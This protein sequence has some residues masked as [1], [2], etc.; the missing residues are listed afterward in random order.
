MPVG[1]SLR[2]RSGSVGTGCQS[3]FGSDKRIW[4]SSPSVPHNTGR[5]CCGSGS[6]IRCLFDTWIRDLGF[7]N[8]TR[9]F[10]DLGSRSQIPNQYFLELCDNFLCKKFYNSLKIGP[11]FFIQHFKNKIISNFVKFE[12]TKKG[13]TTNF[14]SYLSF[15]AVTVLD[16]ESEI[17]DPGWVKIKIRDPG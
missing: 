10:P 12:A 3:E 7:G 9:F 16:P 6:W 11:N 1:S 15:V 2:S 4:I 14:F 5:Q 17:R 13:M 8:R